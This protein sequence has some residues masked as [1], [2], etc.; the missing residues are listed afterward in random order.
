MQLRPQN[1][2]L[3]E[4]AADFR[5]AARTCGVGDRRDG[6]RN[7]AE[8]FTLVELLVVIGIITV[9]TGM[10]LPGLFRIKVQDRLSQTKVE[11]RNL[12]MAVY[13]YNSTYSRY[14]A[15]ATGAADLTFGYSSGVAGVSANSEVMVILMDVNSGVNLNH[16]LNP[17]QLPTFSANRV[18]DTSSPG[19]SIT[20]NQLRDIWGHPYV[21]TLDLDGNKRCRD[22]FYSTSVSKENG[23]KGFNGLTDNGNGFFEL[24]GPV[25]IWSLGPDGKYD[26]SPTAKANAGANRDNIL[27]WK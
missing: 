17:R 21:I 24:D 10:L 13:A 19:L 20:D 27:S 1:C 11:M 12:E 8:G 3:R 25:M 26:D 9:L 16:A 2:L 6:F 18:S 22:A 23:T 7:G 5:Q 15:K 14:P 4:R